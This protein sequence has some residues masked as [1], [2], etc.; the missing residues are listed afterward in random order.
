MLYCTR[1]SRLVTYEDKNA[2]IDE[3]SDVSSSDT[4]YRKDPLDPNKVKIQVKSIYYKNLAKSLVHSSNK[5]DRKFMKLHEMH[6]YPNRKS[7]MLDMLGFVYKLRMMLPRA[8]TPRSEHDDSS[9]SDQDSV[10][11]SSSS[12]YN[13]N[14]RI[15]EKFEHIYKAA[16]NKRRL[17]VVRPRI[18]AKR[19]SNLTDARPRTEARPSVMMSDD[20][21]D[22]IAPR[23]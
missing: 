19:P 15:T 14:G 5:V 1:M 21:F 6:A 22:M 18:K 20:Y 8:D 4:E 3:D 13:T 7:K 17:T 10:D 12:A 2:L 23:F 9:P 11:Q 16:A